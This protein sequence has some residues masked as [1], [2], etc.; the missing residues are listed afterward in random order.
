MRTF[1]F[2]KDFTCIA[3]ECHHSCCRGG[4]EL[5][6][7]DETWE[8]YQKAEGSFGDHIRQHLETIEE[9]GETFNTICLE[10]SHCP[11][12]N[13]RGLCDIIL[14]MGE[15]A[16]SVVCTE[17]PRYTQRMGQHTERTLSLSC[18]EVGRL[19][20]S[21]KD[22]LSMSEDEDVLPDEDYEDE[23]DGEI[24]ELIRQKAIG[25]LQNR[26]FDI[27]RRIQEYMI[28]CGRTQDYVNRLEES[29]EEEEELKEFLNGYKAFED[30]GDNQPLNEHVRNSVDVKE[31]EQQSNLSMDDSGENGALSMN[32]DD[33]SIEKK[34]PD[35][36]SADA[37][38]PEWKAMILDAYEERLEMLDL[39][40]VLDD[41]WQNVM[42]AFREHEEDYVDLYKAFMIRRDGGRNLAYEH[43]MSYFTYRYFPRALQD[44]NVLGKAQFSLLS[45]LVI[46]DMD[47][48]ELGEDHI[49]TSRK[50]SREVEHADDNVDILMEELLFTES[51]KAEN[52]VRLMAY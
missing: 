16:I 8:L 48:M 5:D 44:G 43:L 18:E 34:T 7:D 3:G 37:F 13:E 52:A 40:T 25:I 31:N 30:G 28:F 14:N 2:Y 46:R 36:L 17:Y 49:D 9:D 33:L 26:Q 45:F 1:D 10:D 15:S 12:L 50:Y 21:K 38:S 47:I 4:W 42:N 6:M 11:F 23:I 29:D 24:L 39:M 22:K 32:R 19:L 20:F 27:N 41:E 51:L 35:M